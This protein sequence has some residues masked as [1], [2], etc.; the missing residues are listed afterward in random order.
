MA[1][2]S[3]L[4]LGGIGSPCC[5]EGNAM[6]ACSPCDLP[7]QDL[8]VS[9]TNPL[10]GPGS[11]TMFYTPGP[12]QWLT[13]C[14]ATFNS[15]LQILCISGPL[16]LFSLISFIG[17]SCSGGTVSCTNH[18]AVPRLSLTSHTCSP[19]SLTYT[20]LYPACALSTLGFTSFTVTYP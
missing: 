16:I 12:N 17:V 5:C 3:V 10:F 15:R 1:Q 20:V 4:R 9:W 8:T 6:Q 2:V 19:L 13:P 18:P 11:D 7:L 14:L